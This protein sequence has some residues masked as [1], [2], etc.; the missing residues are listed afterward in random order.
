[1]THAAAVINRARLEH[2]S[3]LQL[4]LE[5]LKVLDVGAGV[6]HLA[7]FFTERECRVVAVDARA[8]TLPRCA[9]TTQ[10]VDGRVAD[11]EED[12]SSLGRFD[13]VLCYGL[14]YHLENPIRALRN[15]GAICDELLLIETMIC[16]SP[17][18]VARLDDETL[19]VNQALRGLAH[20]PSPS[21]LALALNR[22]GFEYVCRAREAPSHP[23]YEVE[24]LGDLAVA[25]DGHLL[26]G[27][28]VAS[29]RELPTER[30]DPLLGSL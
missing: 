18:P 7:R 25:R 17:L 27:V 29:R 2:L 10:Q 8:E 24:E 15:I 26:R 28:F 20:R 13:V 5:R 14:L 3:S 19:S 6:G 21:Y 23:D 11:V 4:P 22:I 30:L 16:D 12:L 1:V 9:G